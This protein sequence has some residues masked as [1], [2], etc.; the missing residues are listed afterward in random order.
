[1]FKTLRKPKP[2]LTFLHLTV[3]NGHYLMKIKFKNECLKL[4]ATEV[5]ILKPGHHRWISTI[6]NLNLSDNVLV[7]LNFG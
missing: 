4:Q 5:E 3:N 7:I 6:V 1:M 2:Y